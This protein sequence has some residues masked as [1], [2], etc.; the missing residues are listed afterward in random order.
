MANN[1]HQISKIIDHSD[2]WDNGYCSIPSAF[3]T[4]EVAQ[5]REMVL[6]KGESDRDL[7][8][9]RVYREIIFS[10][11]IVGIASQLLGETPI[12]FGDSSVV[13]STNVYQATWHTDNADRMDF[14]APDWK[15][16]Y[17]LIRFGIYLQDH[18]TNGRGL[19]V[20][21]MGHLDQKMATSGRKVYL[22]P[23][24]GDLLVW[25]M[26]LPHCGNMT[27]LKGVLSGYPLTYS[28]Q[29]LVPRFLKNPMGEDKRLGIFVAF[30]GVG[31]HL[32][33]YIRYL[34]TRQYMASRWL[35]S[36]RT[37]DV[38][39]YVESLDGRVRVRDM[40]AEINNCPN[41][42]ANRAHV[43]LPY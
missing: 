5:M 14:L 42:G 28:Q 31:S 1:S 43:G 17:N 33:R 15:G 39:Q 36:K 18:E 27:P 19:A 10:S 8:F 6:C 40:W 35:A 34:S 26:R 13:D 37:E 30:G 22:G 2:F 12:Y 41:P 3:T 9:N 32:E 4:D 29:K 25:C 11:R 7:I 20:R 16:R 38:E 24:T 21:S 23:A